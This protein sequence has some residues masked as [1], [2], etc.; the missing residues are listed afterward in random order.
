MKITEM[1][2][3]IDCALKE[4]LS[5][6]TDEADALIDRYDVTFDAVQ[7]RL[8]ELVR[9]HAGIEPTHYGDAPAQRLM[10]LRMD[11]YYPAVRIQTLEKIIADNRRNIADLMGPL[12]EAVVKVT[13]ANAELEMEEKRTKRV[14]SQQRDHKRDGIYRDVADVADRL[15]ASHG[16]RY[17]HWKQLTPQD[18]A[19]MAAILTR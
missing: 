2:S 13:V 7:A 17:L 6:N 19:E 8:I 4:A 9:K 16:V 5:M 11:S 10:S 3:E 14:R 18:L 15:H 1:M 12:V